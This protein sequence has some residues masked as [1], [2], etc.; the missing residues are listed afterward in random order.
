MKFRKKQDGSVGLEVRIG[1]VL[2]EKPRGACG[3]SGAPGLLG[4]TAARLHSLSK[5]TSSRHSG[6]WTWLSVTCELQRRNTDQGLKVDK[7]NKVPGGVE[8]MRKKKPERES[9]HPA[10]VLK[11]FLGEMPLCCRF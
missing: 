3:R 6:L 7:E 5:A 10:A 4:V 1:G 11:G 2:G 9:T 8:R